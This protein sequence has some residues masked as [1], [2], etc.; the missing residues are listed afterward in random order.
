MACERLQIDEFTLA[1]RLDVSVG[2]L[3]HW[4]RGAPAYARL[5]LSALI[6]GLDPEKI[7]RLDDLRRQDFTHEMPSRARLGQAR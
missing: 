2:A 3:R 4:Q 7:N 1:R 5:A 6:A